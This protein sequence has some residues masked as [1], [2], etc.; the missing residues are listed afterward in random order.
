MI[1]AAAEADGQRKDEPD[2]LGEGVFK[3][4]YVL[5]F[6]QATGYSFL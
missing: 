4:R 6:E 2:R 5:R 3:V 1:R